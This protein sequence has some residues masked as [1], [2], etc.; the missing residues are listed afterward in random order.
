MTGKVSYR[1]GQIRID[2]EAA[3]LAAA[4]REFAE[5][6]FSG[7]SISRVAEG[8]GV[9]RT[10]VHYYFKSKEELYA[11]ILTD[12][13][14]MWNQSF[15]TITAEDDPGETL[16]AYIRAKLAFSRTNPLSSKIFAS[17]ILRGAPLLK[18]YLEKN[19]RSWLRGKTRVIQSWIAQG[20]MDPVDPYY[21]IFLIWSSTQHYADFD[22]QVKTA[23]GK[24]KLSERDF[25]A[26]ADNIVHIVLRG[27]GIKNRRRI[28]KR[29]PS[30]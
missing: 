6:G 16:E 22:I 28:L 27:C 30:G 21:L 20:K 10:N 11:R 24:K 5:H 2:N 15:P 18:D 12:V 7:A 4:V 29:L 23:L 13:V 8:A 25:Q 14:E 19:Y 1:I 3:I 17:E 26:I 9:A